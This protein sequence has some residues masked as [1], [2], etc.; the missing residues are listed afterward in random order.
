MGS[1][2]LHVS[3]TNSGRLELNR[4]LQA[5]I[6]NAPADNSHRVT[7][8]LRP[9]P[10]EHGRPYNR[11]LLK[12]L[13]LTNVRA[14][15]RLDFPFLTTNNAPRKWTFIF[16]ENE[17]GKSAILKS[18]ALILAGSDALPPLSEPGGLR[19]AG[20]EADLLRRISSGYV[21]CS[22]ELS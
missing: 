6:L 20:D 4:T 22:P 16:G 3:G 21:V 17:C 1:L 2:T 8:K 10:S 19:Y 18:I 15:R 5:A 13:V 9:E 7:S 11:M 12:R 14:I